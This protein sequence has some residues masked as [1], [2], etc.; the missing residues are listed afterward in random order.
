MMMSSENPLSLSRLNSMVRAAIEEQLPLKYWVTGE[1][2]EDPFAV[3]KPLADAEGRL[4]DVK[5]IEI[6]EIDRYYSALS[7]GCEDGSRLRVVDYASA[8]KDYKTDM[9]AWF[10][11]KE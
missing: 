7:I 10:P 6:D 8:G 3:F 9:G 5:D 1:L 11:T 2:S 4:T